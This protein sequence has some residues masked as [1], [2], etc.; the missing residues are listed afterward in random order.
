M[1]KTLLHFDSI[2]GVQNYDSILKTYHAY[3][4][5]IKINNPIKKIKEISLK[6]LE[7]PLFFPNI[8]NTNLSTLFLILT[9]DFVFF[10]VAINCINAILWMQIVLWFLQ[11]QLVACT[12]PVL[13][14]VTETSKVSSPASM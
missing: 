10:L 9:W 2:D 3:N 6:S 13:E 1:I 12:I 14:I 8:R 4:T 7:M 11:S 5:T